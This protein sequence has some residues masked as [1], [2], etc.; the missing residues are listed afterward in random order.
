[1]TR[2]LIRP[3]VVL[4]LGTWACGQD[5]PFGPQSL[6]SAT[7]AAFHEDNAFDGMSLALEDVR[8]RI[9]P[10]LSNERTAALRG[11]LSVLED[12][13]RSTKSRSTSVDLTAALARAN[14]AVAQLSTEG[15]TQP[16]LDAVQ[17]VLD[18]IQAITDGTDSDSRG[19]P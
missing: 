6:P 4:L 17:L 14:K 2:L 1:M 9:V 19:E 10:T 11:A 18:R 3:G 15:G 12:G 16:D 13:L 5:L 8:M 7:D